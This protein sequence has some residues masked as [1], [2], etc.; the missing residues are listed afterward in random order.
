MLADRSVAAENV[1]V[2]TV[3]YGR[4]W[5][6][7]QQVLRRVLAQGV[8]N[9]VVIDNGSEEK[10]A[11]LAD[12]SF[13]ARVRVVTLRKNW[14]SAGGFYRALECALQ[15]R[16][17]FIWLL[18][19]D[20]LPAQNALASLLT[21][22]EYLGGTDNNALLSFRPQWSTFRQLANDGYD[23]TAMENKFQGMHFRCFPDLF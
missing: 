5:A 18:D 19:D 20:S 22:Y 4:R 9:V 12:G 15:T 10:I 23:K 1:C 2:A 8:G 21:A 7:L 14:G 11:E 17:E 16:A 3:T 6:L 13:G